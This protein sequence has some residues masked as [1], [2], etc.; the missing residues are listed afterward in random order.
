MANDFSHPLFVSRLPC[1][2]S[3][4]HFSS[5]LCSSF[6]SNFS[7]FQSE[8]K[9]N[10]GAYSPNPLGRKLRVFTILSGWRLVRAIILYYICETKIVFSINESALC[11]RWDDC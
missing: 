9:F 5:E 8:L 1:F 2:I 10:W 4:G 11:G 7:L 6:S 3:F